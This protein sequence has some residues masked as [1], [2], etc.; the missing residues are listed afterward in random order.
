MVISTNQKPTI[1]LYRNLYEN[2]D[3]EHVLFD[4]R[5]SRG[6]QQYKKYNCLNPLTAGAAYIRVSFFISTIIT[7]S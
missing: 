4:A 2:T 6:Q 5:H 3:P 1:G 7:S